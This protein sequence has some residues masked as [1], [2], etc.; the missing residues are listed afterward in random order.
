MD[1]L[2]DMQSKL[3]ERLAMFREWFGHLED[4]IK[5]EKR[6]KAKAKV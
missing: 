4:Q 3:E 2:T 1:A 5:D 6:P